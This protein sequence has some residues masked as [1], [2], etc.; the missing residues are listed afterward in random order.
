MSEFE[1]DL[2]MDAPI[3]S[4]AEK[5]GLTREQAIAHGRK[6]AEDENV[7]LRARRADYTK[8]QAEDRIL[9]AE[10]YAAWEYDGRQAG[11]IGRKQ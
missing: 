7:K 3:V 4:E 11:T 9:R 2:D 5:R 6:L 10:A 8:E 1:I